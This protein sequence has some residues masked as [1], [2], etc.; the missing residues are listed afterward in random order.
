MVSD[1]VEDCG[2]N[3]SVCRLYFCGSSAPPNLRLCGTF[4]CRFAYLGS[5]RQKL[6]KLKNVWYLFALVVSGLLEALSDQNDNLTLPLFMWSFLA[7]VNM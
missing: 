6:I 3:F 2:G 5:E 4:L 7:I 1:N